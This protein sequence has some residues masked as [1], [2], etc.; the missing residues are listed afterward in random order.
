MQHVDETVGEKRP[1]QHAAAEDDQVVTWLLLQPRD[2]GGDVSPDAAGSAFLPAAG[3]A[4]GAA[5]GAAANGASN[6][7]GGI[8]GLSLPVLAVVGIGAFL[9]LKKRKKRR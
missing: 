9:F 6:S 3:G 2:L 7:G 1:Q 4:P 5:Q 8:F